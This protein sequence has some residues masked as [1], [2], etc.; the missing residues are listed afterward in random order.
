MSGV[1][2]PTGI[3]LE[4]AGGAYRVLLDDGV[5]VSA[6][7]RGRLKQEPRSGGRVV[8]GDRVRLASE[9]DGAPGTDG[10]STIEEVL[11]RTSEL[12]RAG[13]HGRGEKI[14][15]ANVDRVL[16]V[17]SAT[18]PP[19]RRDS[20]DRYLTLAALSEIPAIL[21]LNKAD[22]VEDRLALE[23]D[24]AAYRKIGY[25]VILTSARTGEGCDELSRLLSE[26]ASL[27]I[28][29]SGV[30]KSSLI[31]A[32]DP[33]FALRVGGVGRAGRGKHTTVGARLLPLT[34]G[35]WVVDT[36]G[37]S[38]ATH[39]QVEVEELAGAF[40][41]FAGAADECR[42][43][44][45]THLHE[46]DCLVRE[47]VEAGRIAASRYESYRVMAEELREREER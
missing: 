40:P 45:C 30:G 9:V 15:A 2:G 35:G 27:L 25:T 39:V 31:N 36:P 34:S 10:N 43:S 24:L 4:V 26:G 33:D 28:G 37:F 21:V 8:P 11:P 47:A 7:L 13:F 12:L 29:P 1:N 46:P 22:L 18:H 6:S 16:V 17:L 14:V 20:A 19:F 42:F 23:A 44:G 3:V 5:E 38:D 32:L 41:E